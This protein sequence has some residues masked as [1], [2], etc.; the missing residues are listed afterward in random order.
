M[1]L[2]V[3]M[4]LV[5]QLVLSKNKHNEAFVLAHDTLWGGHLGSKKCMQ[6]VR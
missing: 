1:G 4:K 5:H 3:E 2:R 6:C